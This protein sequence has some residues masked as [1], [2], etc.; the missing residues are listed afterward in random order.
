M[1]ELTDTAEIALDARRRRARRRAVQPRFARAA[2]GIAAIGVKELRGRMRGRRAFAIL[3]IYLLLLGGFAL[4]A[5]RLVEANYVDR[6]RRLLGLR[7]A[8][9]IGQGIFA[10]L[11]MLMTLQVVFL[12]PSS[13]AGLDQPRAREADPRAADR[14]A[15]QLPGDRRRQAAVRA[16]LRV[17]AHRRV[18]PADGG[19]VRVR[20]RRTGGRPARLHRPRRG[21]A[22]SR[23]V[24]AAVLQ[25]RQADDG[26]D[27]H[28]DLRRPGRDHRHDL[29]PRLLAGHGP[30]RR[31]GQ[32]RG[33]VRHPLA[34]DPRLPEP[35]RRPGRCHVRHR[36][37]PSVAAGAAS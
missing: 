4:M 5:E 1:T 26:R 33:A 3:T 21:R 10:A 8:R 9:Q 28:H 22:R 24:R 11:L 15:D 34:G 36:D 13:T 14:D 31:A 30:V 37:R 25:P 32:P 23:L 6:F 20:R 29:R 2:G 18:D 17:P 19:R 27:R 35:V 12:A 7:R 16:R